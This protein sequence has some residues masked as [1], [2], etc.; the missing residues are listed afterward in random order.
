MTAPITWAQATSPILW[1]NIG[2]NWN[3]PAKADSSTFAITDGLTSSSDH[4]MG[5]SITFA[6]DSGFTDSSALD[7]VNAATFSVNEGFTSVAGI[8][9]GASASFST[10]LDVSKTSAHDLAESI[11]YS[12]EQDY[13]SS[14]N[15]AFEDSVSFPTKCFKQAA[16]PVDC[17]P[18]TYSTVTL[19][20]KKG[21]SEKLSKCLPPRGCL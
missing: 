5:A 11:T 6:I 12:L 18:W 8:E 15:L 17:T 13:S 2:I 21:S 1:S 3:S 20:L 4:T 10:E 9:F 19:P 14:G 16:T 7:A